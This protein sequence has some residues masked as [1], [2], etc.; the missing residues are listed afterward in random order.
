MRLNTYAERDLV[1]AEA[2]DV[3][4]VATGGTPDLDW[5]DGAEHCTN[6]WDAVSGSAALASE[7]IVYDGTGR[8]PAPHFAELAA[9]KAKHVSLISIDAQLAMELTYSERA[10]WK[11]KLYA[12][13]IPT[14]FDH[15][16][17]R[18]ERRG[19]RLTATFRNLM[20]EARIERSA[21]QIVVEHGTTP[22]DA[23]YHEL[24]GVSA[25]DGVTD[26]D[27]LLTLRPQPRGLGLDAGFELHRIG[28]A[29]ASRNIHAAVL[30]ALRLGQAL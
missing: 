24:R 2:P 5:L 8:H 30:D 16:L 7:I 18:V 4:I 20:T 13:N 23:L 28:D 29:V 26:Y 1:V 3:V 15:E 6:I 10:I 17:E 21:E 19:N 25:N 12:L 22:A 27:A 9:G 11:K 14:L